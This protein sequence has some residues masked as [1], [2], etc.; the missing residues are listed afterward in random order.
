MVGLPKWVSYN[1]LIAIVDK[2]IKNLKNKGAKYHSEDEKG[3]YNIKLL[4][5]KF[6]CVFCLK[7]TRCYDV[8]ESDLV[9][10]CNVFDKNA[11]LGWVTRGKKFGIY[12]DWINFAA[13]NSMFCSY[14]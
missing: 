6:R 13:C 14:I 12:V 5:H 4:D 7:D 3:D 9:P 1:G 11:P 2:Y 8:S 10:C